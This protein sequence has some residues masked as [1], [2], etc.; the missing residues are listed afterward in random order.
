MPEGPE[1]ETVRRSLEPLLVG[2]TLGAAWV[3]RNK[4]R[5][6]V[7][8][9]QL[10]FLEGRRVL[11]LG[12]HGKLMW[13]DAEGDGGLLLRLGMTGKLLVEK[14][15]APRHPHTHVVIPLDDGGEELRY[16]DVRR[17]G[18]VVP[19]KR[20]SERDDERGRLGPDPLSWT[21]SERA[22]VVERL[23]STRRSLKDALLD[24]SVV[25]GVGNI[26]ACEALFAAGLSPLARGA[27][28]PRPLLET[29]A[30]AV[31]D[32][33]ESAVRHCGTTFSDFVDA[34][35]ERGMNLAHVHVFQREGLPCPRCGRPVE[36]IVQGARST[37]LCRH[38]QPVRARKARKAS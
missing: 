37:F 28:V 15:G 33:L 22:A 32:V 2:R 35:G 5:T 8:T 38:C 20:A 31:E 21:P 26:Y 29:L 17:F 1:V 11:R 27:S 16:V 10:S 18:E 12:R 34:L 3:S 9:R 19:Y 13:L 7:T 25:A 24:Q 36:R 6:P 4:L 23:K 30:T 14:G